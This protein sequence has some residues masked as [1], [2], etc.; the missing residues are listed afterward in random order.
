MLPLHF[1]RK[2]QNIGSLVFSE[3]LDFEI[4]SPFQ[5]LCDHGTDV[6][7]HEQKPVLGRQ[8]FASN[9]WYSYVF[10]D[11][12]VS[13]CKCDVSLKAKS[14]HPGMTNLASLFCLMVILRIP[15]G[16]FL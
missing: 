1:H 10:G 7:C 12:I 14:Q 9:L 15:K 13:I 8:G 11:L 5:C 6:S 4:M 2:G 16:V 3:H